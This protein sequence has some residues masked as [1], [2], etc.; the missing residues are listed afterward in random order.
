VVIFSIF[1]MSLLCL[2][3]YG[4]ASPTIYNLQQN[5][6]FHS[7]QSIPDKLTIVFLETPEIKASGIKVI[8][9]KN[10]NRVDKNDLSLSVFEKKLS[11]SLGKSK[12]HAGKYT[13][14]WIVLSKEDGYL[15]KGSYI[16]SLNNNNSS[17]QQQHRTSISN[18]TLPTYSKSFIKDN[19]NL[20]SSINQF[21]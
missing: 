10:N 3:V 18:Q 11:A 17:N 20:T 5:Q 19:V 21:M 15:T 13:V 6:I 1:E 7:I 2:S 9:E 8:N 4:H 16:F 12:I 14:K